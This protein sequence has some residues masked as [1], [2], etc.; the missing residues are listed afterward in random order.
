MYDHHRNMNFDE[1]QLSSESHKKV[2]RVM[3]VD[4]NVRSS[5]S[6]Q[7]S[8]LGHAVYRRCLRSEGTLHTGPFE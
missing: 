4:V 6:Y 1:L 2:L 5:I 3:D 7:G 8:L